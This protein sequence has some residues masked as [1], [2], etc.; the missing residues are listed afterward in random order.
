MGA[1]YGEFCLNAAQKNPDVLVVA[2]EPQ[3]D[4]FLLL[5]EKKKERNLNNILFFNCAIDEFE[6]MGTLHVSYSM[7]RGVSSLLDFSKANINSNDYWRQRKDLKYDENERVKIL[8]LDTIIRSLNDVEEISFI[9]IDTQG[10]DLAV[11]RSLGD[12]ISKVKAGMMEVFVSQRV[13]LYQNDEGSILNVISLLDARF[14]IDYLKPNDPASNE[15]NLYFCEKGLS[16]D[17]I[18]RQF[19]LFG[20]DIFDGKFY[21]HM[22]SSKLESYEEDFFHLQSNNEAL[23]IE[24]D[25]VRIE[26]NALKAENRR[27]IERWNRIVNKPLVRLLKPFL[28]ALL[29]EKEC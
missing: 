23:K 14:Q 5:E 20:L 15:F 2:I 24:I 26:N 13:A 9:K 11:I 8:R 10:K 22:P 21:W 18:A 25:A 7:D 19:H 29:M 12:F 27:L 6:G 1:N 28:K 4:L 16:V 17:A 3:A